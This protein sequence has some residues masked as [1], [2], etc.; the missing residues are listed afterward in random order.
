MVANIIIA[1]CTILFSVFFLFQTAQLPDT[2]SRT[3]V[4]ADFWPFIVL[5][6]MFILGIVLLI[7]T[8]IDFKK[9]KNTPPKSDESLTQAK[10]E[11]MKLEDIQGKDEDEIEQAL[12]PEA[13]YPQRLWWVMLILVLYIIVIPYIGF[14]I[15][16]VVLILASAWV[17]GMKKW[18]S[19]ILSSVISTAAFVFIFTYFLNLPLP[20]GVGIFREMSL[21][22]Y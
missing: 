3:A 20:R 14:T 13:V 4:G 22:L 2:G 1:V 6:G 18:Y 19:L 16:T 21:L 17:M 9:E 10:L 7:K 12:G 15:S 5:T 8:F 11:E